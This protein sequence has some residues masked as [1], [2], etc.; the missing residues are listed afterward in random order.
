MNSAGILT[1]DSREEEMTRDKRE[2]P[3]FE[4]GVRKL[5]NGVPSWFQTQ[6]FNFNCNTH[7]L[8]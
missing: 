5:T 2:P 7:N 4:F 3:V 6:T 8:G 1:A